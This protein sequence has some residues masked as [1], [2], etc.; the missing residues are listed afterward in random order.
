[1]HDF[2]TTQTETERTRD[3]FHS[4]VEGVSSTVREQARIH[5]GLEDDTP[6]ATWD[7]F[8][9]RVQDGR[10][11]VDLERANNP[12]RFSYHYAGQFVRFRD[13]NK[14]EDNIGYNAWREQFGKRKT[15]LHR[16]I[17]VADLTK[18]PK[19]LK[20]FETTESKSFH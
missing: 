14:A 12:S 11:K 4:D 18:L 19:M 20:D 15:E 2:S 1:M 17:R 3:S 9:K 5:F 8:I 13:P 10:V 7:E 6:P 16:E